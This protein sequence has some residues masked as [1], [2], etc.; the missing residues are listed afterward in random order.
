[1]GVEPAN[2]VIPIY[3]IYIHILHTYWLNVVKPMKRVLIRSLDPIP[4]MVNLQKCGPE[5]MI[6]SFGREILVALWVPIQWGI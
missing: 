6:R 1:M 5:K 4:L 2:L 3:S